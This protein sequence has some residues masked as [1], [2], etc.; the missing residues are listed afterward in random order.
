MCR[1]D[2][3]QH[4]RYHFNVTL[5]PIVKDSESD[6][7]QGKQWLLCK[8]N[9]DAYRNKLTHTHKKERDTRTGQNQERKTTGALSPNILSQYQTSSLQITLCSIIKAQAQQKPSSQLTTNTPNAQCQPPSQRPS[10]VPLKG[11]LTELV[12]HSPMGCPLI[13]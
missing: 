11:A 3:H 7:M 12:Y 2:N 10:L 1:N 6:V 9:Q 8:S 5:I 13:A 4:T